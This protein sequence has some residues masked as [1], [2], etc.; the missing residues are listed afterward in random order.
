M[1]KYLELFRGEV[2]DLTEKTKLENKPYVCYSTKL[3]KVTY[4]V[5]PV[6]EDLTEYT[7]RYTSLDGNIVVPKSENADGFLDEEGN[8]INIIS[9]TYENGCGI[10]KLDKNPTQIGRNMFYGVGNLQSIELPPTITKIHNHAFCNSG[11]KYLYISSSVTLVDWLSLNSDNMEIVWD[12]IRH[13]DYQADDWYNGLVYTPIGDAYTEIP[14]KK[15]TFGKNVQYIPAYLFVGTCISS[16]NYDGTIEEWNNIEK[17]PNWN[18]AVY[19][20]TTIHCIDGDIEI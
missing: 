18:Y 8:N 11:I 9:N 7:I 15:F 17:S 3:G 1:G 4:T 2:G 6:Q 19:G 10:F 13:R 20:L 12:I 5:V 14:I 16:I